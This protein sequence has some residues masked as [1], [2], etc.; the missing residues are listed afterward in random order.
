MKF[1]QDLHSFSLP[2]LHIS[3][4]GRKDQ[5]KNDFKKQQEIQFL[6]K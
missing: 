4:T 1:V 5:D 3:Y 6:N 2:P